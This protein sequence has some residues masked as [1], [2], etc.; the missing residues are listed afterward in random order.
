LRRGAVGQDDLRFCSRD[1]GRPDLE[2]VG[3]TA[4]EDEISAYLLANVP[5]SDVFPRTLPELREVFSNSLID[6]R[7]VFA[8]FS[9]KKES[10]A[11]NRAVEK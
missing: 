1:Q 10:V 3:A 2:D 9:Y 11:A 6:L 5:S 4:A 7:E 8:L